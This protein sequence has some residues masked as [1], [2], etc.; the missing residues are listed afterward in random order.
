MFLVNC[1]AGVGKQALKPI[2]VAEALIRRDFNFMYRHKD[3]ARKH[4]IEVVVH[5][6]M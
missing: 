4:R 2:L 3:L 6:P 1:D 5:E